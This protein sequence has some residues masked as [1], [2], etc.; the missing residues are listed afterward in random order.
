[1][2]LKRK[3]FVLISSALVL[4]TGS[5]T[6]FSWY[7]GQ[8][9]ESQTDQVVTTLQQSAQT[10]AERQLSELTTSMARQIVFL[11]QEMEQSM[12][13]AA[14]VVQQ[15]DN[16]R[17][18]QQD[19][20][21]NWNSQTGMS[22][23]YIT[24]AAGV[25]THSTE[26]AALGLNLFEFDNTYRDLVTGDKN[27]VSTEIRL[28]Q[29]TGEIYKFLA[30]PRLHGKGVIESAINAGVFEQ[31]LH[32]LVQEKNGVQAIY[33][34]DRTG[35][36]LTE[37][38][39]FGQ[40]SLWQ[41]G[42]T[43]GDGVIKNLI[44]SGQSQVKLNENGTA[45]IYTPVL[46]A[47][48]IRYVLFAQIDSKPYLTTA[49]L[50][51]NALSDSQSIFKNGMMTTIGVN[52][53]ISG[54]IVVLA[55]KLVSGKINPLVR[56]TEA[57]ARMAAGDLSAEDIEVRDRDE[58]GM[59]AASFNGMK[60][61]LRELIAQVGMSS[62]MLAAAAEQLTANAEQSGLA[63]EHIA[64]RSERVSAGAQ[65]QVQ[66][67]EESVMVIDRMNNG[68]QRIAGHAQQ[69]SSAA[70]SA[71]A[72]AEEG[73]GEIQKA[74]RQIDS[75]NQ[76]IH[77]LAQVIKGLGERTEQIERFVAFIKTVADQTN[78][79]ALNATI[80]AARAGQYG[81]GFAVVAA[82]VRKLAEQ[83]LVSA[84]QISELSLVIQAE[85]GEAVRSMERV[86]GEVDAGIRVVYG[87]GVVFRQIQLS[88][89]AVA[90][91]IEDVSLSTDQMAADST[92]V[93]ESIAGIS[94]QVEQTAGGT[95]QIFGSTEEQMASMQEIVA[96]A[97]S[98]SEMAEGLQ[99][100]I[101][102]FRA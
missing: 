99:Q 45:E 71:L 68:V 101:A 61:N 32:Q 79:L 56:M 1:M 9:V 89:E 86:T 63:A 82:E 67:V 3:T 10:G 52:L 25:F 54:L 24:D 80:E 23:L 35:L 31:Q 66:S 20:L 72:Q 64:S 94:E 17:E 91:Q 85:T 37:T 47:G 39:R 16:V 8:Q 96:A 92:Q 88:I 33:L 48:Q 7:A 73:N 100:V 14:L 42:T 53:L 38:L 98:L 50:A 74:V 69:V 30:I 75:I 29:E 44:A 95:E 55:L 34:F 40:P 2:S 6:M 97:A 28:K 76:T 19:D 49:T 46:A 18:L 36:V 21:V 58:I 13:N 83:S 93:A 78:L 11:E 84:Q 26:T 65:M 60:S 22:D 90:E 62:E 102:K 70:Q 87:A 59:L 77:G 12:I 15:L 81:R 5:T 27:I 4:L 43:Q 41:K 51:G 57:A